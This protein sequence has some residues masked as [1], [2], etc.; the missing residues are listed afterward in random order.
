MFLL[1]L[2]WLLL[3]PPMLYL[4][5][6]SSFLLHQMKCF[7]AIITVSLT[8]QTNVLSWIGF[9][10]YFPSYTTMLTDFVAGVCVALV[11]VLG[12]MRFVVHICINM[13]KT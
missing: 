4:K 10:V 8:C 11:H 1:P 13:V 2:R 12:E 3:F 6:A 7:L 5:R 9:L